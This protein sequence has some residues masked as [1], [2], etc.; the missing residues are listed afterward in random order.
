MDPMPTAVRRFVDLSR[1]YAKSPSK[2]GL[3]E[4][5]A[6]TQAMSTH[7]CH[8]AARLYLELL[9]LLAVAE[10]QAQP[11]VPLELDDDFADANV[12]LVFTAH[13]TQAFRR[14]PVAG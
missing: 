5:V 4:L 10:R 13:P 2:D 6:H 11:P 9:Q 7:D 14:C 1:M 12:E 3:A 8:F